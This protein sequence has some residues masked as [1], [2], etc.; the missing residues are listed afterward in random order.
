[1][2]PGPEA[3]HDVGDFHADLVGLVAKRLARMLPLPAQLGEMRP[4]R[5]A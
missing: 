1:M 3:L 4:Q 5:G 2:R